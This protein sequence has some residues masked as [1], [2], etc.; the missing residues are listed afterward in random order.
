MEKAYWI[1]Y[2]GG[3][4]A[5]EQFEYKFVSCGKKKMLRETD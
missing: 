3:N 5:E 2:D 1:G 4:H